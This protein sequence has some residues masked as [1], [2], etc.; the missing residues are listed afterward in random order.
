[1]GEH[2]LIL[3]KKIKE[4]REFSGISE[5]LIYD[6]LLDYVKKHNLDL[7]K[8]NERD[9]KLIVKEIRLILR[10]YSGRFQTSF[11]DRLKLLDNYRINDLLKTHFSTSE[12][13]DFYP[14]LK[15]IISNLKVKSILDLGC[16][17]NPIALADQKIL[18]YA[19]DIRE[20]ELEL[21]RLF[22]KKNKIS[23]KVFSYDLRKIKPNL[24]VV[25]LCLVL[26][27]LDI[28]GAEK[29]VIS[30]KIL[31][32]VKCKNFIISFSSRKLSGKP[33]NR[34]ER[35]WFEKILQSKKLKYKKL[36]SKNEIFYLIEI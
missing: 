13:T 32:F 2:E 9:L 5:S 25:D 19:S 36:Y 6:L 4:K 26:K 8:I 27:V 12:R 35:I 34:P 18:Y 1:M 14:F 11:K 15:K 20:D 29:R 17:L 33:M 3:I 28:F 30:E 23:G 31:D 22:F 16:G 24:P 7:K 10:N 21:I